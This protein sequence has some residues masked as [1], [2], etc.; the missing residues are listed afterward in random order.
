MKRGRPLPGG[1]CKRRSP[2]PEM[3]EADPNELR[4]EK[5]RPST[6]W[7]TSP[8]RPRRSHKKGRGRNDAPTHLGP[9]PHIEE[10]PPDEKDACAPLRRRHT[11]VCD[12]RMGRL[13]QRPAAAEPSHPRLSRQQSLRLSAPRRRLFPDD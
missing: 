8:S 11:R 9:R 13:L 2:P 10:G 7:P 6:S 12:G 3:K 5:S 4:T 1:L